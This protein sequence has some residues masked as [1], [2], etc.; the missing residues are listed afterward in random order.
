MFHQPIEDD[1]YTH[2]SFPMGLWS[3]GACVG[4]MTVWWFG[5]PPVHDWIAVIAS[6]CVSVISIGLQLPCLLAQRQPPLSVVHLQWLF[7]LLAQ[8]SWTGFL[9]ARVS[10]SLAAAV[11]IAVCVGSQ[12]WLTGLF[13]RW[14]KLPW[15]SLD[16]EQEGLVFG[17][18]QSSN[19]GKSQL[20]VVGGS[21]QAQEDPATSD[22]ILRQ[23]VDGIDAHGSRFLSGH[24]V[25][26]MDKD[27]RSETIALSFYPALAS[28]AAVELECDA[29]EVSLSVEHSNESGARVTLR[30][31]GNFPQAKYTVDWFA[32]AGEQTEVISKSLP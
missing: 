27:Q 25:V 19:K 15:L 23:Y 4:W 31:Q 26:E 14:G 21:Q 13:R 30:R 10:D 17:N 32:V 3:L 11:V 28:V 5:S 12:L 8:I 1:D 24:V 7:G 16:V 18:S 22:Q 20:R 9:A 6:I 29:E 2:W